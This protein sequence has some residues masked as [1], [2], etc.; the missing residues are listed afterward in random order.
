MPDG[1]IVRQL[2][3][4]DNYFF[5]GKI[6]PS[7]TLWIKYLI[8]LDLSTPPFDDRCERITTA[9]PLRIS[10]SDYPLF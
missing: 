2:T 6:S 8:Y 3:V 1:E 5:S 9:K 4:R 10:F 7:G